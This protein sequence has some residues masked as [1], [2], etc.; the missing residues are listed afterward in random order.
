MLYYL[1]FVLSVLASVPLASLTKPL[2]SRW[3]DM[4]LKHAWN[5]IPEN[6]ESLGPPLASTM[7]DL[8][9]ALKSNHE[10]ALI[11]TLYEVSSPSHPRH[12]FPSNLRARIRILT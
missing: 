4:R 7:I 10:N 8:R 12:V 9:I 6:W 11:D 1:L 5:T 2:A 3:G